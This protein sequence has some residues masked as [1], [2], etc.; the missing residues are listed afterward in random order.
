MCVCEGIC[1]YV[2]VGVYVS[3]YIVYVYM[4]MSDVLPVYTIFIVHRH[5]RE[6]RK[7][8]NFYSITI[9]GTK[10]N[11]EGNQERK[12]AKIKEISKDLLR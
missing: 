7:I 4:C 8:A 6:S 3:V 11:K 5:P 2:Y 1:V 10:K 9:L 12:G